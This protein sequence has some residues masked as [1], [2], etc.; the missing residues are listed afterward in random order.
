MAS[1]SLVSAQILQTIHL[2]TGADG[3]NPF[4]GLSLGNDG[5]F[6]GTTLGAA[7]TVVGRYSRSR[8]MAH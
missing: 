8:A 4:A 7:S 2:F 3:M 6:Y 5:N 1:A